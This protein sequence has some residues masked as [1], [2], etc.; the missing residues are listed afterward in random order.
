MTTRAALGGLIGLK[1]RTNVDTSVDAARLGAC[2]T[3]GVLGGSGR[4]WWGR[5]R[6]IVRRRDPAL[7]V[8]RAPG[9][10]LLRFSCP[11]SRRVGIIS[12][13]LGGRCRGRNLLR[14]L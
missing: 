8:A 3:R 14:L 1:L 9:L 10:G 2:A 5:H 7:L 4:L 12:G 11:L 13:A 6:P